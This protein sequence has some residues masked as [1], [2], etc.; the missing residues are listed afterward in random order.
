M[1]FSSQRQH[2]QEIIGYNVIEN[3][4]FNEDI[5]EYNPIYKKIVNLKKEKKIN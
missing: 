5:L 3:I 2:L 4:I 1:D